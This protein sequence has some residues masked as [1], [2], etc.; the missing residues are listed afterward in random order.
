[1]RQVKLFIAAS[2]DGYIA[3]PEGEIDWLFM[4]GNDYGYTPFFQSIDTTLS[5]HET[6]KLTLTFGEF[7]YVGKTNYVFSRS[8]QPPAPHVTFVSEDPAAFVRKLKEQE[9][10]D[11]WLVGGGQINTLLLNAD[12]IDELIVAIHPVILGEGLPLFAPTARKAVFKTAQTTHYQT[13]LVQV[14][15]RRT[16]E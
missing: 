16:T 7:P 9:G 10:G 11:I 4:D 14:T 13:G 3:G 15:M 1:M 8:E 12:L 2:L 6:Y 5:G